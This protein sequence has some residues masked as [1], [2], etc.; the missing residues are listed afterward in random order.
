LNERANKYLEEIADWKDRYQKVA[1]D[2]CTQ[3]NR[4]SAGRVLDD[5]R[6]ALGTR[7]GQSILDHA[8]KVVQDV[9]NAMENCRLQY[10]NENKD[11]V[12]HQQD[13]SAIAY[14]VAQNKRYREVLAFYAQA[15]NYRIPP[16]ASPFWE[17]TQ[18]EADQGQRARN[19]LYRD[20]PDRATIEGY[21]SVYG[22]LTLEGKSF[23]EGVLRYIENKGGNKVL[24]QTV[25][26]P[27]RGTFWA[28]LLRVYG[29]VMV[30]CATEAEAKRWMAQIK[31]D[32]RATD[33]IHAWPASKWESFLREAREKTTTNRWVQ[34]KSDPS[35]IDWQDVLN[36]RIE[37]KLLDDLQSFMG[38][39]AYYL[40]SPM[41]QMGATDWY[42]KSLRPVWRIPEVGVAPW[43]VYGG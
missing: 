41:F 39:P 26:D 24:Y 28:E 6:A 15:G 5:V 38:L 4:C 10:L 25:G 42:F 12:R 17:L 37:E 30:C 27:L 35:P 11:R 34:S 18:I 40:S 13:E 31:A 23:G 7:E 43:G 14:Y 20:P 36:K 19:Q 29:D 21:V 32:L 16:E 9:A 33:T 3:G 1:A 2:S 8:K 22:T